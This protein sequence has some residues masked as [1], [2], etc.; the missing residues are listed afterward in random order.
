MT[1]DTCVLI[2]GGGPAGLAT[3]LALRQRGIAVT[4]ADAMKPPID[5]AC[6]EG[7]MP[8]G[9]EAA[10]SLGINLSQAEA[11]P[12]RGLRFCSGGGGPSVEAPFPRGYGLGLRR[13]QLH[14][15][16]VDHAVEAGVQLAW[17]ARIAGI[18]DHG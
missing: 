7:I 17:G 4:V 6:G 18:R 2:V 13:V 12:F 11:Q 10:R 5:K 3:A 8:D 15:L 16:M 14:R 9:I 1:I